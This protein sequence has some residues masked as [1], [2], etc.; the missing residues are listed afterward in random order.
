MQAFEEEM[1]ARGVQARMRRNSWSFF[2][3]E[4]FENIFHFLNE[5]IRKHKKM[6]KKLVEKSIKKQQKKIK[7]NK[8][9]QKFLEKRSKLAK[10]LQSQKKFLQ[11]SDT[12]SFKDKNWQSKCQPICKRAVNADLRQNCIKAC[13]AYEWARASD[14]S[15]IFLSEFVFIFLPVFFLNLSNLLFYIFFQ[16]LQRFLIF[17]LLL[18]LFQF[19][20]TKK[21]KKK[22]KKPSS[23]FVKV[24]FIFNASPKTSNALSTQLSPFLKN[25]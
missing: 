6:S 12:M 8:K 9:I 18:F 3:Q 1:E 24:E 20:K 11:L 14:A 4:K 7:T 21:N 16:I 15:C 23:S 5:M 17:Q 10:F 19:F 22:I 2:L 13:E 25:F